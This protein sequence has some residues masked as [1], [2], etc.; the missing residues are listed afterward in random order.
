MRRGVNS[1]THF[2]RSPTLSPDS[3]AVHAPEFNL[4]P[5]TS[6]DGVGTSVHSGRSTM[7]RRGPGQ[8]PPPWLGRAENLSL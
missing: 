3:L 4:M 6:M 1:D 7:N 8:H 5:M 2:N